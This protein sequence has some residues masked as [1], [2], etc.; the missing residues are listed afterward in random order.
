MHTQRHLPAYF[1]LVTLTL[2]LA[3]CAGCTGADGKPTMQMQDTLTVL[4]DGQARGHLSFAV[5]G[6]PLSAGMKQVF[7]AG[8]EN[9][10]MTFDGDVNFSAAPTDEPEPSE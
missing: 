2:L 6:S 8:P 9:L 3:V 5:G 10:N 4:Q 7:F 1:V